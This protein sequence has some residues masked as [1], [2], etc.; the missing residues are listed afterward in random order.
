[1]YMA[2]R[3]LP[4]T[5]SGGISKAQ[6]VRYRAMIEQHQPLTPELEYLKLAYLP[7]R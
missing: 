3:C 5:E 2:D 4:P 1:M 7:P 6:Y